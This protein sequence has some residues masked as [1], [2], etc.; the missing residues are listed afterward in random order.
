MVD[1]RSDSG[2]K[3]PAPSK[4]DPEGVRAG[5]GWRDRASV[6]LPKYDAAKD[7]V[8]PV[9]REGHA[10]TIVSY[11][12][13]SSLE[14]D[15]VDVVVASCLLPWHVPEIDRLAGTQSCIRPTLML[16]WLEARRLGLPEFGVREDG[17]SGQI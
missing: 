5:E 1:A 16:I 2:L 11:G 4:L 13:P 9:E 7:V 6:R 12:R 10:K 8:V 17:F 14:P 3:H 15:D